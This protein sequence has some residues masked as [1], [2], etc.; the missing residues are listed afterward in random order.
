MLDGKNITYTIK[1][2]NKGPST[3]TGVT[4]TDIL[5]A[6]EIV[7]SSTFSYQLVGDIATF[8]IGTLASGQSVIIKLVVNTTMTGIVVDTVSVTG[9]DADPNTANNTDSVSTTVK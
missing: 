8:T 3:D 6:S 4:L 7:V 1:V 5:P 2:T 9:T